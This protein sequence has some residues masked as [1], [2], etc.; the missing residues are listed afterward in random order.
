MTE[1]M[2]D[3]LRTKEDWCQGT[4]FS[5]CK[6]CLLGA[7]RKLSGLLDGTPFYAK[8][9]TDHYARA[10]KLSAAIKKLF[11]GRPKAVAGFNDCASTTFE[12]VCQVIKEAGV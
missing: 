4:Y 7:S 6:M 3:L 12:D 8:G 1:K 9:Y 11:P 10:N 2:R 5:G